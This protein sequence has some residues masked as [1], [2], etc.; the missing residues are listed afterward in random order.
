MHCA[1][2]TESASHE[3]FTY[4]VILRRFTPEKVYLSRRCFGGPRLPPALECAL[5]ACGGR[6][7]RAYGTV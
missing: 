6:Y 1:L 7:Y 3:V 4:C 2:F 5:S